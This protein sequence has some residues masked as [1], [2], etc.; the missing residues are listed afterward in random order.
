MRAGSQAV[1]TMNVGQI[2]SHRAVTVSEAAPMSDVARLMRD[3]HVGAVIVTRGPFDHC[4]V[5]GIITDRD[6]MCAQLERTA[7]LSQL[8][9]SEAMT[10]DPLVLSEL[11]PIDSAIEH[12]KARGVR[13]APVVTQ[14]GH[15]V[16]MIS[17]DDLLVY[18]SLTLAGMAGIVAHQVRTES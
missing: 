10:V 17:A 2:C 4:S 14:A 12:M 16:G 7:D 6:V 3:E 9:A 13:R 1:S 5:V 18:L 15:P 8:K 11:G